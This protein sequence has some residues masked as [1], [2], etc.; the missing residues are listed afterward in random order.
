MSQMWYLESV[1]LFSILCPHKFKKYKQ[2]HEFR[3]YKKG[4]FLYFEGDEAHRIYLIAKGKIKISYYN[5]QQEE[6]VKSILS[7]GEIFGE[8]ALLGETKRTEFA[9]CVANGT[10]VCPMSVEVLQELIRDNKDFS[11]KIYKFIGFRIRKLERR[12]N[13]LMF[14]DAKTR[15]VDFIADLAEERGQEDGD[16]IRVQHALTQKDIASLIGASRP[17]TNVLIKS[18]CDSNQIHWNRGEL[19]VVKNIRASHLSD[20]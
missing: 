13:D 10:M 18:L 15:L 7:K 8:M 6:V 3:N 5:D 14:K 4:E 20:N 16:L 11:L 2:T 12:L 9:Q 1:N 19:A 17:T